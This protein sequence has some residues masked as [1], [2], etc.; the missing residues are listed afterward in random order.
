MSSQASKLAAGIRSER[1]TLL[2]RLADE[3]TDAY[4]HREFEC[5]TVPFE[6]LGSRVRR[7]PK[8]ALIAL[9]AQRKILKRRIVSL[10]VKHS[11]ENLEE[12]VKDLESIAYFLQSLQP[13]E[14]IKCTPNQF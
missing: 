1:N 7:V 6:K 4:V 3:I 13:V 5:K 10:V 11:S 8:T 14:H 9:A 12:C 2:D